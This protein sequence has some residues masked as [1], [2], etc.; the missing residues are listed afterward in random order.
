L[1][2]AGEGTQSNIFPLV[3][4]FPDNDSLLQYLIERFVAWP[5]NEIDMS[6][7]IKYKSQ[8]VLPRL[9]GHDLQ[10]GRSMSPIDL[11]K[12]DPSRFAIASE[13]D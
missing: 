4:V 2:P 13:I 5:M 12:F 10:S 8:M 6:S 1:K 3:A 9:A 11:T 7:D